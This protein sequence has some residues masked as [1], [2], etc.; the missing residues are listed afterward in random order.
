MME[1]RGECPEVPLE[2]LR[3]S[4]F[5]PRI[6]F[7]NIDEMAATMNHAMEVIEPITVRPLPGVEGEWEIVVGER[8]FRAAKKAGRKTIP[9]RIRHLSDDEAMRMQVV[10]NLQRQDLTPAEEGKL[11]QQLQ[12][13]F[14]MTQERIGDMV[15]K[16]HA[17]VSQRIALLELPK[18]VLSALKIHRGGEEVAPTTMTFSKAVELTR[19]EPEDQQ[20]LAKKILTEGMTREEIRSTIRKT[21]EIKTVISQ[22]KRPELRQEL[23]TRFLPRVFEPEVTPKTVETEIKMALGKAIGPTLEEQWQEM[24]QHVWALRRPYMENSF[25]REWKTGDRRFIQATIWMDFGVTVPTLVREDHPESDF[26]DFT[27]ADKYAEQHGGYCS[28][29][30]ELA[31]RRVWVVYVKTEKT[32]KAA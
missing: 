30:V 31:G 25:V 12:T 2:K 7:G 18:E 8:R 19:L 26:R 21:E 9:C 20:T 14:G 23:E 32:T 15:G 27:A 28:G 11:F 10:E 22:V 1:R 4:P 3:S 17:Y 6:D 13:K 29:I 24:T 16:T 5:N